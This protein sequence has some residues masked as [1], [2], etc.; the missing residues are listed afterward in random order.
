[1][2]ASYKPALSWSS[3]LQVFEIGKR[4]YARLRVST[5][6]LEAHVT[7]RSSFLL[8]I[9]VLRSPA[10]RVQRILNRRR[11]ILQDHQDPHSRRR[12]PRMR[13]TGIAARRQA[14]RLHPPRR[15]LSR[16]ESTGAQRPPAFASQVGHR[17]ARVL[18]LA[19][20][21]KDGYLYAIQRGEITRL[22]DTDGR[23]H[24]NVYETFCDDWGI[25]G[26]YHEYPW[27]TKFD[28]DGNLWVMLTLTGSFTSD[29]RFRGWCLRVTP[30]GK[31]IPT[32]SGLRSPGGHRLQ[33]QGRSLLPENQGP[34][35]GGDDFDYLEPGKFQGHPIGNKWYDLAPNMRPA[36]ARSRVRQP[37]LYRG[38]ERSRKY[39]PPAI[40]QPYREGRPVAA[41][42][43]SATERGQIRPVRAPDVLRRSAPQQYRS[44][45]HRESQGP[46]P[47]RVHLP[48]A[49][50]SRRATCR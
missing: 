10:R 2:Q 31:I 32:A 25:S 46:L 35:N 30:E 49:K 45:R 6:G 19:Y 24:A 21:K 39:N 38:A 15:H 8:L 23:G 33:R 5:H 37:D 40:I 27:M 18:G 13:R 14:R 48:S 43:S 42:A 9:G 3:S 20:N 1:M 16:R 50:G 4:T 34:W 12:D 41:A 44:R 28:K 36:A 26:D 17:H 22:K 11:R 7:G 47:G 29:A